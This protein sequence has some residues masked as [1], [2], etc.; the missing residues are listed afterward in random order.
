[1]E[2]L[3]TTVVAQ[4]TSVRVATTIASK[5]QAEY[6]AMCDA[7]EI[8]FNTGLKMAMAHSLS[9]HRGGQSPFGLLPVA[10]YRRCRQALSE[11]LRLGLNQAAFDVFYANPETNK[12]VTIANH[13]QFLDDGIAAGWMYR[14]GS[15]NQKLCFR[16]MWA[17]DQVKKTHVM[18]NQEQAARTI[19]WMTI[20]QQ[21]ALLYP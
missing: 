12:K 1:M 17:L 20:A 10:S 11:C 14:D 6:Q 5:L 21:A 3:M 7:L 19:D 15:T 2:T 13:M 4:Q 8:D 18:D 16:L 9:L